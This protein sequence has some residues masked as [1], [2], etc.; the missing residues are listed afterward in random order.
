MSEGGVDTFAL[1]MNYLND[2]WTPMHATIKLFEIH[3]IIGS[4]MAL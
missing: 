3:E 2:T 1:V 4:A